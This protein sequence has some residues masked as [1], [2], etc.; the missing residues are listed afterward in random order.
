MWNKIKRLAILRLQKE[1]SKNMYTF[2]FDEEWTD[3][4]A[5]DTQENMD[6]QY[7]TSQIEQL[8]KDTVIPSE[9]E[10][11]LGQKVSTMTEKQS[12]VSSKVQALECELASTQAVIDAHLGNFELEKALDLQKKHNSLEEELSVSKSELEETKQILQELE[13]DKT[14]VKQECIQGNAYQ[15]IK[16]IFSELPVERVSKILL[17]EK[18][19]SSYLG[20]YLDVLKKEYVDDYGKNS[21]PSH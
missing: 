20:Q 19:L 16:E 21:K 4:V 17:H 13:Q 11:E 2:K 15:K 7:I 8:S 12:Q 5:R 1:R 10:E 3:Q 6:I 9:K 14:K 18:L